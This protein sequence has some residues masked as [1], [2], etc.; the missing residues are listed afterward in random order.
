M[1]NYK[2]GGAAF[3]AGAEEIEYGNEGMTLRDYFAGQVI[4]E[5]LVRFAEPDVAARL[6]Y[7]VAE[8]MIERRVKRGE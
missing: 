7:H 1:S 3:P 8:A 5:L 4:S 2:T 6:A